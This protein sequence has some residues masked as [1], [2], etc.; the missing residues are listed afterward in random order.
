MSLR[1]DLKAVGRLWLCGGNGGHVKGSA[2]HAVLA[3]EWRN[4]HPCPFGM[5]SLLPP[6][7]PGSPRWQPGSLDGRGS[8]SGRF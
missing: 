1:L 6:S 7:R 5:M 4:D 2:P 3:S 8:D